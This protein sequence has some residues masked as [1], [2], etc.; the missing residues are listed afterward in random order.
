M[1]TPDPPPTLPARLRVRNQSVNQCATR[2]RRRAGY[3]QLRRRPSDRDLGRAP[4][5]CQLGSQNAAMYDMRTWQAVVFAAIVLIAAIIAAV[6]LTQPRSNQATAPPTAALTSPA[7]TSTS[8]QTPVPTLPLATQPP[9]PSSSAPPPTTA[10]QLADRLGTA[11]EA[12]DYGALRVLIDPAGF[13]YQRYQTGGTPPITPDQTIDRLQRGT[14][15]PDGKLHVTVQRRPILPHAEFQPTC[16]SY[17]ASTW[18]QY[19]TLATPRVELLLKNEAGSWYW[20]GA[21][22]SAPTR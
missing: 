16:D 9:T 5:R 20:C 10:E 4:P 11:L 17:V 18:T 13:F 21:L 22:F 3:R 19:D 15:T 6:V 2:R 1:P 7:P 14:N 12:S 8:P